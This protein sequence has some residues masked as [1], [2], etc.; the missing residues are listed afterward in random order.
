MKSLLTVREVRFGQ[1]LPSRERGLKSYV[2][3]VTNTTQTVAPLAGAWIEIYVSADGELVN[4]SLPSRERGLKSQYFVTSVLLVHVAPL[5]GAWI[6]I[7]DPTA[8]P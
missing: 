5:A 7:D 1:S 4:W 2:V 8:I 6:E 3:A